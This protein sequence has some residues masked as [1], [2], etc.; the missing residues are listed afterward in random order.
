M[1]KFGIDET[2]ARDISNILTAQDIPADMTANPDDYKDEPWYSLIPADTNPILPETDFNVDIT[3]LIEALPGLDDLGISS[4]IIRTNGEINAVSVHDIKN[5]GV[6]DA[7]ILAAYGKGLFVRP[8]Q[9][10]FQRTLPT[11]GQS[12][13]TYYDKNGLPFKTKKSG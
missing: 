1:R 3:S 6:T 7:D 8:L 4:L 11:G 10:I 12:L 5:S 13:E 2:A 9:P